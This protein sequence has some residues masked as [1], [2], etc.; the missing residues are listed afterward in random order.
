MNAEKLRGFYLGIYCK[1]FI[2]CLGPR[3]PSTAFHCIL[4]QSDY[5][6]IQ[7]ED[8]SNQGSNEPIIT[9]SKYSN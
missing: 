4:Q 2:D 8:Q 7:Y 6:Y 1:V 9:V 3:G 5:F